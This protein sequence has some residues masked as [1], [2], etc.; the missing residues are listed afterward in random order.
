MTGL[1]YFLIIIFANTIGAISG[2]GGGVIIKP[3]LDAIGAHSLS[4]I[5]FYSSIAVFTMA[6]VSTIKQLNN[7][8]KVQLIPV[9]TLSIG[10]V[11]G[12]FLGN[13]LFEGALRLFGGEVRVQW[14]QILVTIASLLFALLYTKKKWKPLAFQSVLVYL[15]VG[16]F[17]GGLST[18]LGIGGGPINV[19]ILMLFF[20]LDIK[21][22]TVYSIITIFFSQLAKLGIIG[23][24]GRY[25]HYDLTMLYW[26]I[27]AAIVGGFMGAKLSGLF[28]EQ[29]VLKIYQVVVI[30]VIILNGI[31]GIMLLK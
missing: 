23:I 4:A 31:N 11:I 6:I 29:V 12:G 22:A 8:I 17:L 5:S 9:L 15:L 28:S 21:D 14:L 18:F 2:M 24:S 7:G 25:S 26:I 30:F 19:A 27:P 10:S 1:I 20:G 13:E 3:L 16:A